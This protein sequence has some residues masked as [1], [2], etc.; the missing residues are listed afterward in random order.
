MTFSVIVPVYNCENTLRRC[1]ESYMDQAQFCDSLQIILIEKGSDDSSLELAL[2][3]A[4][5]YEQV[6]VLSSEKNSASAKRN[7]GLRK[8]MGDI[9]CFADSD[10]CAPDGAIKAVNDAFTAFSQVEVIATAFNEVEESEKSASSVTRVAFESDRSLTAKELREL[11]LA[12]PF[13]MGSV[14]NKYYR[15]EVLDGL[16]FNESLTL[17]E[18]MEFLMRVLARCDNAYYLTVPTYNYYKNSGSITSSNEK[19]FDASG[20]LR[21]FNAFDE[22]RK[23][24]LSGK[25]KS[26]LSYKQFVIAADSLYNR[27][28]DFGDE[29][30]T[31]ARKTLLKR[32][33]RRNISGFISNFRLEWKYNIK[34]TK[35]LLFSV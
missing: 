25:E 34:R 32:E 2:A 31:K 16:F 6:T 33:L 10:D 13:V 1:V 11:V 14:W 18:D 35:R 4:K 21:Y 28:Y 12:N 9:I 22:I 17:C 8:A 15:R 5:E 26:L 3:L 24:E 23:G 20:T 27:N 29:S 19:L 30:S 7:E